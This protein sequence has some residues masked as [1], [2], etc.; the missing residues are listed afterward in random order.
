M[1]RFGWMASA[2]LLAGAVEA[3]SG[4]TVS[5]RLVR[6]SN[7]EAG[8]TA[9]IEDVA[10]ILAGSLPFKNFRL[11]AS[12]Q[13]PLPAAA[14][15]Q[16]GSYTVACKGPQDK[17]AIAVSQGRNELLNTSVR[18]RDGKPLILGGFPDGEARMVLVF[19]AR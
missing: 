15:L 5:V 12:A 11:V 16:L 8:D 1:R 6:A 18:L 10:T 2:I 17:L 4:Q 9:G 13:T 19:V 7:E 3:W 14:R